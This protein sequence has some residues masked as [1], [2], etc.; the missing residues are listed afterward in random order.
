M[1]SP[2]EPGS[3]SPTTP[4]SGSPPPDELQLPST[5]NIQGLGTDT[6]RP[7]ASQ[8]KK[9]SRAA[10]L[11]RSLKLRKKEDAVI[12]VGGKQELGAPSTGTSSWVEG[13]Q[14]AMKEELIDQATVN[15]L[16]RSEQFP[17]FLI[18]VANGDPQSSKTHLMTV[19]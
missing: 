12:P 17:S 14:R 5:G 2:P 3:T 8:P 10:G 6:S 16:R 1:N 19:C 7:I 13:T 11:L 15:K 9:P 18:H 4:S